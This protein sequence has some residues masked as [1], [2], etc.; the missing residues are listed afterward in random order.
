MEKQI[1]ITQ[2]R[3]AL[4]N[5]VDEVQTQNNKYIILRHGKPAAAIVPLHVYERWKTKRERLSGLIGHM[6]A[7][8]GS[9]DPDEI[10]ALTL[11][12]QQA[13]RGRAG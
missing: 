2:L 13:V 11:E 4:G 12:A 6:Q 8:S 1:D 10:M 5:L 3:G 9:S 7:S